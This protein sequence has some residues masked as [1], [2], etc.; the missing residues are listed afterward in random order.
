MLTKPAGRG[1]LPPASMPFLQ[2]ASTYTIRHAIV[3]HERVYIHAMISA[4]RHVVEALRRD[5][6]QAW[7]R[8]DMSAATD[9]APRR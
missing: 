2:P 9:G 3:C 1:G 6:R 4:P 5:V 8:A 7:L